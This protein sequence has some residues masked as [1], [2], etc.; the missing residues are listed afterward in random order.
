MS[1][2][3]NGTF[4]VQTSRRGLTSVGVKGTHWLRATANVTITDAGGTI[5]PISMPNGDCDGNN[6]V[7]TD[8]YLIINDSF[9]KSTGDVGFDARGDLDG[10]GYVGTDDY[11]ILNK[12]F[13]DSGA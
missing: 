13:D 12:N 5:A 9:D 6:I 11:L 10:S 4:S 7:G 1:I 8:D 2:A 3:S